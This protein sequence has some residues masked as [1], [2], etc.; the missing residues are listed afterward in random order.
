MKTKNYI[1]CFLI[2]FFACEFMNCNT[3]QS[4]TVS[5]NYSGYIDGKYE[6]K[7][8]LTQ[9]GNELSGSYFYTKIGT[10]LKLKGTIDKL[11]KFTLNEFNG[12]GSITGVFAGIINN[13][14]IT[15]NWSKPDGTKSMSFVLI[16]NTNSSTS[17]NSD[18]AKFVSNFTS[19]QLPI[20]GGYACSENLIDEKSVKKFL[21]GD[22]VE[23]SDPENYCGK[24][25][26]DSN[27]LAIFVTTQL[28]TYYYVTMYIYDK[29]GTFSDKLEVE[30][31][32]QTRGLDEINGSYLLEYGWNSTI[33]KDF[34]IKIEDFG[35]S[36]EVKSYIIRNG[37]I[38]K[39]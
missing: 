29:N 17:S 22:E 34:K 30:S 4:Q 7:M 8:T 3:A 14:Q 35:N 16:E 28:G 24:V 12:D 2:L 13:S 10:P 19:L 25:R 39:I 33:T 23:H 15:G 38:V 9:K 18:F 5:K 11:N 20:S 37:K 6:I 27:Y 26:I 31:Y 21:P 32:D 36:K 1:I